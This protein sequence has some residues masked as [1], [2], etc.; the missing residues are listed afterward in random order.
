MWWNPCC[1]GLREKNACFLSIRMS[2]ILPNTA[3]VFVHYD[4]LC[5][6]KWFIGSCILIFICIYESAQHPTSNRLAP[7]L[8]I[9]NPTLKT[10]EIKTK[11]CY[12]R[13]FAGGWTGGETFIRKPL[14]A[15]NEECWVTNE[16][17]L[18][19]TCI[20]AEETHLGMQLT[21]RVI[22]LKRLFLLL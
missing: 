12:G 18:H 1:E 15:R 17:V 13:R 11:N 4:T 20:T 5:M 8:C 19:K 9:L 6:I 14:S 10:G 7:I 3:M 16:N 21:Q 22:Q 2:W